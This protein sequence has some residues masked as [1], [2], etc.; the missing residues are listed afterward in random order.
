VSLWEFTL[1]YQP[2][3]DLEANRI[4]RLE[5][6]DP[7]AYPKHGPLLPAHFT[8]LTEESW[9]IVPIGQWALGEASRQPSDRGEADQAM[10]PAL[11]SASS[12]ARS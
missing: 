9:L 3:I 10:A 5:A 8:A 7:L 12:A 2:V 4:V 1:H 11:R 6:L